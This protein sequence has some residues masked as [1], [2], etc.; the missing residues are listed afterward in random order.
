MVFLPLLLSWTHCFMCCWRDHAISLQ[1][2]TIVPFAG[3]LDVK[4]EPLDSQ[5]G[6]A[7]VHKLRYTLQCFAFTRHQIHHAF[8][9]SH[10]CNMSTQLGASRLKQ[11][12]HI[13]CRSASCRVTM[14]VVT[15]DS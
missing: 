3:E 14:L 7:T 12:L 8:L 6:A 2:K 4:N 13:E 10:L 11:L 9:T 1:V 15:T 5:D